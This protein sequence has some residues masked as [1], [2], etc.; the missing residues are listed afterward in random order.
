MLRVCSVEV[1]GGGG[2]T[3]PV[4]LAL[5]KAGTGLSFREPGTPVR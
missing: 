2:E 3:L 4:P 5:G 1:P